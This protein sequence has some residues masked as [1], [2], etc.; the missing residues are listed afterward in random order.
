VSLF[1]LYWKFTSLN[2]QI[3]EMTDGWRD[4]M[5]QPF[6]QPCRN[7]GSSEHDLAGIVLSSLVITPTVAGSRVDN[8]GAC[9]EAMLSDA[10]DAVVA[11]IA[12][13]LSLKKVAKSFAPSF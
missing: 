5:C 6:Q 4:V 12:A 3:A 10:A 2:G 7:I 13:T 1:E 8:D 11:R 9:R